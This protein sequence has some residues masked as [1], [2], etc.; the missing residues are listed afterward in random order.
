MP[1]ALARAGVRSHCQGEKTRVGIRESAYR[2]ARLEVVDARRRKGAFDGDWRRERVGLME[3]DATRRGWEDCGGG[4]SCGGSSGGTERPDAEQ[5]FLRPGARPFF[6]LSPQ[7]LRTPHPASCDSD[8]RLAHLL[9]ISVSWISRPAP[10][11]CTSMPPYQTSN[12][13]EP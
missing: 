4:G 3:M 7:L 11:A 13:P 12:S 6:P 9:R 2:R 10:P 5:L 1:A 8:S